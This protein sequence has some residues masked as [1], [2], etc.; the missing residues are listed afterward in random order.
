[1]SD[2][3]FF[4]K[5]DF[6]K[7]NMERKLNDIDYIHMTFSLS[8]LPVDVALSFSKLFIPDMK[9]IDGIIILSDCYEDEQKRRY[10]DDKNDKSQFWVNLIEITGIFEEMSVLEAEIFGDALAA[11]WNSKIKCEFSLDQGTARRITD[12]EMDEVFITID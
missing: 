2:N 5:E 10:L 1:M 11:S 6:F 12:A 9:V 8:K 4:S 3:V 7:A